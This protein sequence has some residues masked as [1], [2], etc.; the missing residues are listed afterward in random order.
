MRILL[1]DVYESNN[2]DQEGNLGTHS[3]Q[4]GAATYAARCGLTKDFINRRGRWRINV[5]VVDTYIDP[6]LPYP[7]ARTASILCGP[8]GPCKHVCE[9]GIALSDIFLK[10]VVAPNAC[11]YFGEKVGLVLGKSL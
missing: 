6:S 4:K 2:F 3:I 7:D 5:S 9:D 11:R 10:S 8:R 1:K